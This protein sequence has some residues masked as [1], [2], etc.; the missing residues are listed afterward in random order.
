MTDARIDLE[1][2]ARMTSKAFNREHA[3][4][5]MAALSGEAIKALE[6]QGYD[7]NIEVYRSLEMRYLGQNHELEVPIG[8]EEFDTETIASVWDRFHATHR[9]RFNFDIPGET[10]ELISIKLT[11]VSI[12]E[13]PALPI[14]D[15]TSGEAKP[16]AERR[17]FFDDGPHDTPVVQRDTL[18]AGHTFTGPVVIEEP[19][20]VTVVRPGHPVRID[21]YG[22]ILIGRIAET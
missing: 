3:N 8:F 7:K 6:A 1:R 4:T 15:P 18:R 2:S 5:V 11:A 21:E 20:S 9:T 17:V 10:I 13:K 19:T 12:G 14:L 16:S 22:N